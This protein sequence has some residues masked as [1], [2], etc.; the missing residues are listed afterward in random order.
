LEYLAR[1]I[2]F[3]IVALAE[4]FVHL[5]QILKYSVRKRTK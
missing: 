5:A 2:L 4:N 1:E 3:L